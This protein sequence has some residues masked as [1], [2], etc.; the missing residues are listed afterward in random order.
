M[1]KA[2]PGRK[3][4]DRHAC[5]FFL[6]KFLCGQ[7]RAEIRHQEGVKMGPLIPFMGVTY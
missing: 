6:L 3:S 4:G 5:S 7:I 1:Q 2:V